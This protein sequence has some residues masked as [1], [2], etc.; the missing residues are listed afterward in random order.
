MVFCIK[1]SVYYIMYVTV[2]Y[3][4]LHK[5]RHVDLVYIFICRP[6]VSTNSEQL[7]K[8]FKSSRPLQ[9]AITLNKALSDRQSIL[10][11]TQGLNR[12]INSFFVPTRSFQ[13]VKFSYFLKKTWM[14][15]RMYNAL[16][17]FIYNS[18]FEFR[19]LLL[20]HSWTRCSS[21]TCNTKL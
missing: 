6:N 4:K 14:L 15:Q 17:Y 12:W 8:L 21:M 16:S 2:Q 20:N 3:G 9:P 18:Y 7:A 10:I 19:S 13:S 5:I 11:S 1:W